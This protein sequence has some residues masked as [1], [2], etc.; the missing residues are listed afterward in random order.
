MYFKHALERVHFAE[1]FFETPSS[2]KCLLPEICRNPRCGRGKAT[3]IT[4]L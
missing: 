2:V 3:S 4:F 1:I